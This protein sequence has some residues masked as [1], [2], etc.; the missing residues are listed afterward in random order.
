MYRNIELEELPDGS[1]P[2]TG[3][4][5]NEAISNRLRERVQ[6]RLRD[7]RPSMDD[8]WEDIPSVYAGYQQELIYI[9]TT[10]SLSK[11]ALSEEELVIG[12]ILANFTNGGYKKDRVYAMRESLS[13]L[14]RATGEALV[15]EL[16]EGEAEGIRG[17]LAR[18]WEAWTYTLDTQGASSGTGNSQFG[19]H[20]F[21]LI[22]LGLVL[23]CLAR[24]S[25]L[26]L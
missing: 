7:Y 21:G 10:Y 25:G 12:T 14:V 2:G 1:H 16:P 19:S 11:V 18:A 15:G 8:S 9:S 20:S 6:D 26:T 23:E 5:W 3:P 13:F 22:A 24:M 4:G 17:Q